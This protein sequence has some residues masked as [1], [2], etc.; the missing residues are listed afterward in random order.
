MLSESIHTDITILASDGSI[1]AHRAV[2]AAHSPVFAGMFIHDFKEKDLSSINIP[3][4]SIAVCQAFLDYLY[5]NNIQYQ[6]FLTHRL[7]LLKAADKYDVTDLKDECQESLI[8]DIDSKNVLERLQTAFM[9]SLPRLKVSCIEY[10]VKFGKVFDI[11]KEFKSFRQHAD[12]ELVS[13]VV[14]EIF[15]AWKGIL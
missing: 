10:L 13:E 4:M 12:K 9:Y 8:E 11:K 14:D 2:L 6:E 1:G 15:S 7:D 5:S 3:D